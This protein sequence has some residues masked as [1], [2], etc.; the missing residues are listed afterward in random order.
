MPRLAMKAAILAAGVS[1][2]SAWASMVAHEGTM[3]GAPAMAPGPGPAEGP[4]AAPAPSPG[5]GM[6]PAPG[7]G[8]PFDPYAEPEFPVEHSPTHGSVKH[9]GTKY[10][11][12]GKGDCMDYTWDDNGIMSY[13]PVPCPEEV[14]VDG[15]DF[16][17]FIDIQ[18]LL[19]AISDAHTQNCAR[20]FGDAMIAGESVTR[21]TIDFPADSEEEAC[22]AALDLIGATEDEGVCCEF[23]DTRRKLKSDT[24]VVS[25][26]FN[27]AVIDDQ[28]FM[29]YEAAYH[30]ADL[31]VE[32]TTIEP[33][34]ELERLDIDPEAVSAFE[35]AV[36]NGEI[37]PMTTP[38]N[39]VGAPLTGCYEID[40]AP[41]EG[42]IH[43]ESNLEFDIQRG[44][45]EGVKF[46]VES[47]KFTSLTC[48]EAPTHHFQESDYCKG[49]ENCD[50]TCRMIMPPKCNTTEASFG[51]CAP[52]VSTICDDMDNSRTTCTLASQK[53]LGATVSY[54]HLDV[55]NSPCVSSIHKVTADAHEAYRVAYDE[56]VFAYNNASHSCKI[57]TAIR[58]YNGMAFV[59]HHQNMQ[60][61]RKVSEMVC[62][63]EGF[64]DENAQPKSRAL[65]ATETKQSET[66]S[67][68]KQLIDEIKADTDLAS[69]QI[70]CFASECMISKSLEAY[71][72]KALQN[73]FFDYNQTL[74]SYRASVETFNNAVADKFLKKAAAEEAFEAFHPLKA[75]AT[76]KF[77]KDLEVYMSFASGAAEGNCGLTDC[78]M[79]AVC[80]FEMQYK[81]SDY[82]TKSEK[83]CVRSDTPIAELCYATDDEKSR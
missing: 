56:W 31:A 32:V 37:M 79:S 67:N 81:F 6:A 64:F 42:Y 76:A 30:A 46:E 17:S 71:K 21:A 38:P 10:E 41:P 47:E 11:P 61:I 73:K 5:P 9:S 33:Q 63:E 70:Q 48:S 18:P 12:K 24:Y 62:D 26:F 39:V 59:Q 72:F 19:D 25:M 53:V 36:K 1:S 44:E 43:A 28:T 13:G 82:V 58:D 16:G 60:N 80:A 51:V 55:Q 77:H 50:E 4:G 66:C 54:N 49:T 65:L 52:T 35:D 29:K 40:S 27:P 57:G 20:V 68:I 8:M 7:P 69:K 3:E 83:G 14:G 15:T 75:D 34:E 74:T 2:A 78:E 22:H 23:I 45:H